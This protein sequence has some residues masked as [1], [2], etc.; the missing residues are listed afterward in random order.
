MS[1]KNVKPCKK[2]FGMSICGDVLLTWGLKAFERC[3]RATQSHRMW[4][5]GRVMDFKTKKHDRHVN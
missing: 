2:Y 3:M 4:M 5:A 1:T